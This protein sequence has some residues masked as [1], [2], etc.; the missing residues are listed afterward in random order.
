MAA[1]IFIIIQVDKCIYYIQK[2]FA[3]YVEAFNDYKAG[4]FRED[5]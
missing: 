1:K 5:I 4:E 2:I 3:F